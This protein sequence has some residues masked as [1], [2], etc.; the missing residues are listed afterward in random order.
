MRPKLV[1]AAPALLSEPA[2]QPAFG[3]G[4]VGAAPRFSLELGKTA[5]VNSFS[6]A[7]QG[8]E[9]LCDSLQRTLSL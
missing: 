8:A 4:W 7:P 2:S 9:Q 6:S 1:A 3:A 5:S